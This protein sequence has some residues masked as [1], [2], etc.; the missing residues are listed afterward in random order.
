MW[1]AAS[2]DEGKQ[3]LEWRVQ[4]TVPTEISWETWWYADYPSRS[5]SLGLGQ[6]QGI[7]TVTGAT[8]GFPAGAPLILEDPKQ[9]DGQLY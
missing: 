6:G 9:I 7:C 1:T 8:R 5:D 2:A 3:W 4:I